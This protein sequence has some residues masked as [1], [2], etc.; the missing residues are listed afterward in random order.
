M[1]SLI[2]VQ[3]LW[4]LAEYRAFELKISKKDDPEDFRLVLSTLD[5]LQY[6]GYYN[7]KE[8]ELVQ[9]T[10][11]WMCKGKTS[12][13]PICRD[14]KEIAAEEAELNQQSNPPTE[15]AVNPNNSP[16]NPGENLRAPASS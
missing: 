12:E 14:P 8:N 16:P 9:Y 15:P 6:Y 4:A 1:F 10:R 5:P 13:K 2:L 7:V 3:S 11:T